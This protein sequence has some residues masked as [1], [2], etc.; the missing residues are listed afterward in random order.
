MKSWI[1]AG[2]LVLTATAAL[3]IWQDDGGAVLHWFNG[4]QSVPVSAANPLPVTT[5][6]GSVPTGTAGSPNAAV[7]SVQ[8]VA[9][10]TAA[11]VSGTFWQATQPVS[12]ASMPLPAGA[13]TS[14]IQSSVIGTIGAGTAATNALAVAGVFNSALPTLTNGQQAA[15]QL[16]ASGRQIVVG[17]CAYT[18]VAGSQYGLAITSSTPLTIPA[19]ATCATVQSIG[20]VAYYTTVAAETPVA[21]ASGG[22]QLPAGSSLSVPTLAALQGLHFI[23]AAGVTINVSYWK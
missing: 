1:L 21:S 7:V 2:A 12:A 8:G 23:G 4:T 22:D 6:G 9:G 10:G 19:T 17:P 3:A 18:P 11:P 13:A 14:A 16:D 5:V 20:G 15:V